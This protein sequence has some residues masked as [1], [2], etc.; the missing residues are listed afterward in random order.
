MSAAFECPFKVG[1]RIHELLSF[2]IYLGP[3]A[4]EARRFVPPPME[5]DPSKPDATVT[6]I[7]TNGFA[8]TYDCPVPIGRAAWGSYTEG[9]Q[10]YPEGFAYWR[11]IS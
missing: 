4:E 7:N 2:A 6:A 5:L 11:I 1:D 3:R 10:C 8:Y 9:G